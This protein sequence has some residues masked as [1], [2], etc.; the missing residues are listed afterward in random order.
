MSALHRAIAIS[1]SL[2][3]VREERHEPRTLDGG[4]GGALKRCA[5]TAALARKHLVLVRAELFEQT[6]VLVIDIRRPRAAI[7][8][9][10]PTTILA[11]A[12]KLLPRHVPD[13]LKSI[14][15]DGLAHRGKSKSSWP[16]FAL[17]STQLESVSLV[18]AP[19]PVKRPWD[20]FR[21]TLAT[22]ALDPLGRN[23]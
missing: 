9:A 8:R 1:R 14:E 21:F 2:A 11:V 7:T 4:A 20:T 6:N 3:D 18:R 23:G 17:F 22:T 16:A 10:K 15:N 5:A 13:F 19:R 12:T